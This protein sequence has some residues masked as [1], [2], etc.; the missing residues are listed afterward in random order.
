[1][2][3]TAQLKRF[4]KWHKTTTAAVTWIDLDDDTWCNIATFLGLHA[5]TLRRTCLSLQRALHQLPRTTMLARRVITYFVPHW[6]GLEPSST[7]KAVSFAARLRD[8]ASV[9][10]RDGAIAKVSAYASA[11]D[12]ERE[13]EKLTALAK[14]PSFTEEVRQLVTDMMNLPFCLLFKVLDVIADSPKRLLQTQQP[15]YKLVNSNHHLSK[16]LSKRAADASRC[17]LNDHGGVVLTEK[18]LRD[19]IRQFHGLGVFSRAAVGCKIVCR[20]EYP[21]LYNTSTWH[22]AAE[23]GMLLVLDFIYYYMGDTQPMH[24][25]TV[26]GNN[27]YAHAQRG[28]QRCLDM[29]NTS[30]TFKQ[31]TKVRYGKVLDFLSKIGLSDRPWRT[32]NDFIGTADDSDDDD[33]DQGDGEDWENDPDDPDEPDDSD[34]SE[35]E[36]EPAVW[37]E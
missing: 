37:S 3:S 32:L 33:D 5:L 14:K 36:D 22:L 20:T 16:I 24:A 26:G 9:R 18:D 19:A 17:E 21:V 7:L 8:G 6:C 35:N 2:Q 25:C 34:D 27:A 13:Y 30:E 29:P 11:P 15:G 31:D 28:M 10:L 4:G 23:K 12:P 1:M